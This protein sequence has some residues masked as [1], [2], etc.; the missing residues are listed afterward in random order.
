MISRRTFIRGV[1]A[2]AGTL[3]LGKPGRLL[4]AEREYKRIVVLGDPHLPVRTL[5]HPDRKTQEDIVAAKNAVIEDINSWTDVDAVVAVG[6]IVA[7]RA[8]T[9]EY[10]Y[11]RKFFNRLQPPLWVVNGNHEFCYQDE[12]TETGHARRGDAAMRVRK[13]EQYQRFWQLPSRWYAK[14]LGGYHLVFLSAEGEMNTSMLD[15]QIDW[16]RQDLESHRDET[17]LIFFH[18]PLK[19]TLLTYGKKINTPE[20]IAQPEKVLD[21]ILRANPQ[22][23][24]WVSGHTHTSATNYSYAAPGINAYLPNLTD[25]HN[26]DMDRKKI[27]TNS[28]YLYPDRIEVRTFSHAK[29]EWMPEF[30]RRYP[31]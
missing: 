4:A 5:Q 9:A 28:L 3:F 27:W 7:Q 1:L 13:L 19:D 17:T 10:A 29:R 30:D 15:E 8:I 16:L 18:G 11:I 25:I 31:K 21:E 22:V 6:D 14:E 26:A 2:G 24:L 20:F 23:R 12:P